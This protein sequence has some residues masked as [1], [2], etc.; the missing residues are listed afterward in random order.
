MGKRTPLQLPTKAVDLLSAALRHVRDA[1]HLID[2]GGHASLD[3]AYHLAAFGPECARKAC[4][5]V[6][7]VDK[8][9]GH[10]A[11]A[12][13]DEIVELVLAIDPVAHRYDPG[14]YR[15][16]FPEL[17]R[18]AVDSRYART[19]T[20][21]RPQVETLCREARAAVDATVAAL[22]ADGRVPDGETLW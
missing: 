13:A 21:A 8:E 12:L 15:A 11:A 18:W 9:I 10:G 1:E 6:R 17:A 2:A 22:W 14:S 3:Q 20:Y 4:L 5:S 7:W 16:R 19:G